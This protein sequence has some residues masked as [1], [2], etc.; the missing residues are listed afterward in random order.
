MTLYDD[1]VWEDDDG[2]LWD[3]DGDP[4]VFQEPDYADI[5]RQRED[6]LAPIN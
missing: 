4:I 6:A 5:I 1:G 3:D 2:K